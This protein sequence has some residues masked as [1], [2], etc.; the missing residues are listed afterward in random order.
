[1]PYAPL[2]EVRRGTRTSLFTVSVM[3]MF[4]QG[5][6]VSEVLALRVSRVGKPKFVTTST[7]Y[8]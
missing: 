8:S 6:I 7:T 3:K 4:E 2:D 5:T 1:M